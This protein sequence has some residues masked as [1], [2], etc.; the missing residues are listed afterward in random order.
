MYMNLSNCDSKAQYMVY[1]QFFYLNRKHTPQANDKSGF[2]G[3]S[4]NNY[5]EKFFCLQ[6]LQEDWIEYY[7]SR[8]VDVAWNILYNKI[9]SIADQM[10]PLIHYKVTQVKDPWITNEIL[11]MIED[12]RL[13]RKAKKRKLVADWENAKLARNNTN[14]IIQKAKSNFIRENLN[15]HHD[16]SKKFWKN[17]HT[18]LPSSKTTLNSKISLKDPNGNFMNN[19][20]DIAIKMNKHFTN[21]GPSLAANL[22]DP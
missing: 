21:I 13:V 17:I 8:N 14:A 9:I 15:E 12:K 22:N 6:L 10:C 3:R 5:D 18:I 2:T 7:S 16:D 19:D 20:K 4:Y 1:H 11:E